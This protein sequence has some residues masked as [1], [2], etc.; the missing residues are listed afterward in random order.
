MR[1]DDL[2][3]DEPAGPAFCAVADSYPQRTLVELSAANLAREIHRELK[4]LDPAPVVATLRAVAADEVEA[5]FAASQATVDASAEAH[6]VARLRAELDEAQRRL[7]SRRQSEHEA[8]SRQA[9]GVAAAFAQRRTALVARAATRRTA[10][11]RDA[12]AVLGA[13]NAGSLCAKCGC[14]YR[15]VLEPCEYGCNATCGCDVSRCR[16]CG[17]FRCE[18]HA[19]SHEA[20]CRRTAARRC[21][22]NAHTDV[23]GG[24]CGKNRPGSKTCFH[25]GRACCDDCLVTCDGNLDPMR[26]MPCTA[27]WCKAC[28]APGTVVNRHC[29]GDSSFYVLATNLRV[30]R[31]IRF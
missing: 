25:C 16:R 29:C 19:L 11:L 8:A 18:D 2:V 21:G 20:A 26:D 23:L 5:L 22:Y 3:E 12:A 17:I 24:C 14:L 28:R 31:G 10:K 9:R 13:H 30:R 7:A 27:S 1:L 4:A 6:D 15:T